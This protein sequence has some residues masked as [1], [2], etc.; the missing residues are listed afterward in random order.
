MS[1]KDYIKYIYSLSLQECKQLGDYLAGDDTALFSTRI[2][3][4]SIP[5]DNE[6]INKFGKILRQRIDILNKFKKDAY[7]SQINQKY[8]I[9]KKN[10]K[11]YFN[12]LG[13]NAPRDDAMQSSY[14]ECLKQ[15]RKITLLRSFLILFISSSLTALY[16]IFDSSDK[17][18]VV[19]FKQSLTD[20]DIQSTQ[21]IYEEL[22]FKFK[23]NELFDQKNKLADYVDRKNMLIEKI[24]F[25]KDQNP[26]LHLQFFNKI[27]LIDNKLDLDESR[28]ELDE[29]ERIIENQIN[30][31]NNLNKEWSKLKQEIDD[32]DKRIVIYCSDEY[33]SFSVAANKMDSIILNNY[34]ESEKYLNTLQD[35]FRRLLG[36]FEV[37]KKIVDELQS[38]QKKLIRKYD[39]LQSYEFGPYA[40]DKAG[41]DLLSDPQINAWVN[42]YDE[43][44]YLIENSLITMTSLESSLEH[45]YH[46]DSLLNDIKDRALSFIDK[47]SRDSRERYLKARAELYTEQFEE[48]LPELTG[49]LKK[50]EQKADELINDSKNVSDAKEYYDKAYDELVQLKKSVDNKIIQKQEADKWRDLVIQSIL[51]QDNDVKVKFPSEYKKLTQNEILARQ[52][53]KDRAYDKSSE[54]YKSLKYNLEIFEKDMNKFNDL[55]EK[56]MMKKNSMPLNWKDYNKDDYGRLIKVEEESRNQNLKLRLV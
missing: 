22:F 40:K 46:L 33:E 53:Y 29:S 3:K 4:N 12:S 10:Y 38:N 1:N 7:D 47:P 42:E 20:K 56:I 32:L 11:K 18:N 9:A 19:K 48:I 5:S 28:A 6:E 30:N 17:E 54:Y 51:Y 37:R 34:N 41:F 2:S 13:K 27:D 35:K 49:S 14:N 39:D 50:I 43:K 25:L 8:F 36:L 24:A 15:I 21:N 52:A 31:F 26:V 55:E 16:I 44:M 23:Y 45:T